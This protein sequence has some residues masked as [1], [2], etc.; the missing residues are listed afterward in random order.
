VLKD[1]TATRSAQMGFRLQAGAG[2]HT[3]KGNVAVGLAGDP[4]FGSGFDVTTGGNTLKGNRAH[5]H[6]N[7]I[8]LRSSDNVVTGNVAV[9]NLTDG[10]DVDPVCTGNTWKKNVFHTTFPSCVR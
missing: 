4:G 2:G 3:L 5:E 8:V 7:G 10:A 1:N 6:Q 9:G